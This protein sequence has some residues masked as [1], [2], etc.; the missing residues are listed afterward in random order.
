V[1][2]EAIRD[3]STRPFFCPGY[4][5]VSGTVDFAVDPD[6]PANRRMVDLDRAPGG[7]DGPVRFDADLQLL[8]PTAGGSG[9]L[10]FV[11]PNRG[12]P[13][14]LY[15]RPGSQISFAV[16]Q[17]GVHDR[18]PSRDDY[19]AAARAAAEHLVAV[20]AAVAGYPG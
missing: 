2:I 15:E 16:D 11:V 1:T 4:E 13:D 14:V 12:L 10:L 6:H 17:P 7:G 8:R 18:Y 3:T 5:W 20:D 9:K 19:A